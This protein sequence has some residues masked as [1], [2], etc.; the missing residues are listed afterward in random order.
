MVCNYHIRLWCNIDY[1]TYWSCGYNF[2]CGQESTLC[3]NTKKSSSNLPPNVNIVIVMF[4][5]KLI[6]K[7]TLFEQAEVELTEEEYKAYML[8]SY[9]GRV[10]GF[11]FGA[12]LTTII[13]VLISVLT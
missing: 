3:N 13:A 6:K 11:A 7:K 10:E 12:I 4:D 2:G 5:M 1:K 9:F 8:G